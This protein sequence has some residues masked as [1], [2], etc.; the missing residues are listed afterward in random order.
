MSTSKSYSGV[1]LNQ[2]TSSTQVS[3]ST[4]HY[5]T[6][7]LPSDYIRGS[8]SEAVVPSLTGFQLQV[9][10][11]TES[12][13]SL[14]W[15]FDRYI[16][17]TGWTNLSSGT[18][19]GTSAAG[20]IWVTA[21]FPTAI[22]VDADWIGTDLRFGFTSTDFTS[23]WYGKPNPL[24]NGR[25]YLADGTSPLTDSGVEVSF[26]FRILSA[27]GDSGVD[28]LGNSYRSALI[29]TSISN[30]DTGPNGSRDSYW[31]SAPQPSKF[32]VVNQYFDLRDDAGDATVVTDVLLDPITPGMYAHLYWTNDNT[33]PGVDAASW[34]NLLWVPVTQ[35]LHCVN[36]QTWTLPQPITAKYVKVE[37]S[38]LQAQ[39]Y[40]PGNFQK[41]ITYKKHPKWVL[42][43]FLARILA[44][45]TEDPFTAR[46]VEV[47]YDAL[48]FAFNYYRDDLIQAPDKPSPQQIITELKDEDAALNVDADTLAKIRVAFQPYL[49]Q[50]ALTGRSDYIL[51]SYLDGQGI[52]PYSTETIN[53]SRFLVDAVSSL[54]R[55]PVILEK[56]YPVMFF[57]VECRHGYRVAQAEFETNKAYFAGVAEIAF[58]R[59]RYDASFDSDLYI[60]NAGDLVNVEKSDFE[61]VDFQWVT[62]ADH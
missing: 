2:N 54:D 60:E 6:F 57:F 25:A 4:L 43:Y 31:L 15:T 49:N 5:Q 34:E 47:T 30:A 51:G 37:Y 12:D 45:N 29:T 59:Q 13:A 14:D 7:Q 16:E 52:P 53:R 55:D 1:V 50:P 27:V 42:D 10:N 46:R 39:S 19:E 58:L 9:T 21:Y 38:H 8:G 41:A 28:F 18:I 26:A 3:A 40:N 48:D 20:R 17:G 22:D 32:A 35:A 33:G 61:Q 11:P 36:R 24:T 56:S 23:A 44:T 62:Y